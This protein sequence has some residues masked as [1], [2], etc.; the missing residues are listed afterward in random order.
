VSH[1]IERAAM[2]SSRNY[3]ATGQRWRVTDA[4]EALGGVAS[5][6]TTRDSTNYGATIAAGFLR[7]QFA[8]SA[9]RR[10]FRA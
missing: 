10:C 7:R 2:R 6:Q 8:F 5:S 1:L 4:I 9:M 3:P